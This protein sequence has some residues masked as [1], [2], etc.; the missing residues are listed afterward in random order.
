[1]RRH[2]RYS[3]NPW[4]GKIP[5]SRKWQP[6]PAFLPGKFHRQ[7]SLAGYYPWGHKELDTTKHTHTHTLHVTHM[8]MCIIYESV[9]VLIYNKE[10]KIKM[11]SIVA[12]I[13][14]KKKD[15]I[16]GNWYNLWQGLFIKIIDRVIDKLSAIV[17]VNW[18]SK[19]NSISKVN[20]QIYQLKPQKVKVPNKWRKE[21]SGI[22][23]RKWKWSCSVMSGSLL[24]CGL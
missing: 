2:R 16:S 13:A 17:T 21:F 10:I 9:Y 7:R 1:M 24:P 4:V 20:M 3:F 18:E 5:W 6:T 22:V 14:E 19:Y 8:C 11:D 15:Q 23:T 12:I